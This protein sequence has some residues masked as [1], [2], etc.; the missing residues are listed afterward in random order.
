MNMLYMKARHF[1]SLIEEFNQLPV[2]QKIETDE[3]AKE[4]EA[5]PYEYLDKHILEDTGITGKKV[6]PEL[7]ADV[8]GIPYVQFTRK[9]SNVLM[10]I[11]K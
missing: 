4:F 2:L 6:T 3:Q 5:Q 1:N 10:N 9:I 8:V 11:K 7:I